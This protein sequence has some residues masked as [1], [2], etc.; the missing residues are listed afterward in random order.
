[1]RRA[2][3]EGDVLYCAAFLALLSVSM[4]MYHVACCVDPGYVPYD[5]VCDWWYCVLC[6]CVGEYRVLVLVGVCV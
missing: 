4:V 6:G 5:K 2:F 1:M 3:E